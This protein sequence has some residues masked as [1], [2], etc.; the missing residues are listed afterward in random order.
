MAGDKTADD[1]VLDGLFDSSRDRSADSAA[2]VSEPPKETQS[3]PPAQ[4][5]QTE[6]PT[7]PKEGEEKPRGYKDPDTGRFVPLTELKTEREKR[8]EAQRLR[9]EAHTRATELERR[10]ADRE[11]DYQALMSRLGQPQQQ[12]PQQPAQQQPDWLLD[13][14]GAARALQESANRQIWSARVELSQEVM[15]ARHADYDDMEKLFAEVAAKDEGLCQRL[16][17]SSNPAKFAYET[18][19]RI[20]AL[21]KIGGDVNGFEERVRKEERE[22]VLSELKAGRANGTPPQRFPGTLADATASGGQGP[23]LT[24]EAMMGDV[25]S[26]SRKRR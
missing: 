7:A 6:A 11:R 8:Q 3:E 22:K 1:G 21:S 26:T 15:R 19:K 5:E 20:A 4:A 16:A 24:D 9:D 14:E 25:F 23:M 10:L 17:A 2:L 13:P 18:G 12:Q